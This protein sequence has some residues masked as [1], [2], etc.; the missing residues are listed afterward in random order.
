MYTAILQIII[1]QLAKYEKDQMKNGRE[2]EERRW[3]QRRSLRK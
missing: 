3:R 1:Y 2:I